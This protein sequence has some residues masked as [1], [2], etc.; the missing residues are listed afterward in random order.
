MDD[1]F[2]ALS[3]EARAKL[4]RRDM[5]DWTPPMLAT[6][7][8]KPF[9][10]A[11]WIYERK[12]DGQRVLAFRDGAGVRLMS[13]NRL[14]SNGSYPE[15]VDAIREQPRQRF[16]ADGEVVAFEGAVTSFA[17]LQ[18]RMQTRDE[19]KSRRSRVPVYY[20]L[21]DLLYLNDCDTTRLPQRERKAL[22][23]R[24]LSFHD[25]IRY[26]AHRNAEGEALLEQACAKGWEGLIAKRADASYEHRR[27]ADWLKFKCSRGQEFVI[28][29]YTDPQGSRV[30]FGSLLLGYYERGRLHYAGKVGTGFD[31]AMLKQ[32]AKELG[33]RDRSDSPFAAG[34]LPTRGVHWVE[35]DL[36]CQVAFAEWTGDG[37]LRHPRFLGLR[38]DKPAHQVRREE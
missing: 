6:L 24:S 4:R 14:S 8:H 2:S 12:L 31:T 27:S 19:A 28:G 38:S 20:Y 34:S 29:G 15:L 36:V 26:T 16:I 11:G 25:P 18:P 7:T 30:G 9:S 32:L 10:D 35:P 23:R 22:L 13:R 37:L 3:D 21:F 17:R 33:S 1:P 5:P